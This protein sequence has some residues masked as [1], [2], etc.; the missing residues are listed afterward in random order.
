MLSITIRKMMHPLF[1][2]M[3]F[4]CDFKDINMPY[5]NDENSSEG[6]NPTPWSDLSFT[7][8]KRVYKNIRKQLN[9]NMNRNTNNRRWW[10]ALMSKQIIAQNKYPAYQCHVGLFF[11]QMP[12]PNVQVHLVQTKG[13][14]A[15][16]IQLAAQLLPASW[17]STSTSSSAILKRCGSLSASSGKIWSTFQLEKWST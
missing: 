6:W 11:K 12:S 13:R 15:Y 17:T 4:S 1:M 8:Q 16:L 2:A 10:L 5:I 7:A 3:D 9:K 14:A